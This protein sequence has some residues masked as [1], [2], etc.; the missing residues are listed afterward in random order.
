[1]DIIPRIGRP[2]RRDLLHIGRKSGDPATALRFQIIARLGLRKTSPEVADELD[3]AR[4]TVV[5]TAHRYAEEGIAGLYDKRR[6]NGKPKADEGFRHHVVGLLRRTPEDVGWLRPTWTRELLCLQM[7]RDGW[8]PVGVGTMGRVLAHVGA[9]LGTP[10]P[11][12]LCPWKRDARE[13]RLAEIRALEM[14]ASAEEPVLYSDEVDIHLN[15][16]IGR[17]WMLR[18]E[19]RRIVTPGKNE[20]FYLAGALDVRTGVLHTTGMA[21]K[22]AALFC[23]L[24]EVLAASYDT[25]VRRIHLI[26]D[27]YAIHSAQATRRTLEALGHRI[28]L[29]FLPP[30]CPD[31]NRIERV[32]QDLHA[33]VTRNHR[34][35]TLRQLLGN[36]RRYLLNYRWRRVTGL[37]AALARAA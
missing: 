22:S 28:V 23:E 12:V 29:H 13:R 5:R 3:V 16:K 6:G 25:R 18:G 21:R 37:D 2:E 32:W 11:V 26:V 17:D 30:Y 10:K 14:G 36:C 7:T 4:S 1:M 19:Q 20:K 35:K 8:A 34:C 33:N 15:P 24:L 31:A 9:R 27:N